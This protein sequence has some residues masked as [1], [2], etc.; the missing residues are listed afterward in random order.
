MS[1]DLAR[2]EAKESITLILFTIIHYR[3][4]HSFYTYKSSILPCDIPKLRW[5][6][7]RH[8][9]YYKF[10]IVKTF[11]LLPFFLTLTLQEK[12]KKNLVTSIIIKPLTHLSK[13]KEDKHEK[14]MVRTILGAFSFFIETP[15]SIPPVP[16]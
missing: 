8:L 15:K 10:F 16:R 4:L 11:P 9:S 6:R 1:H 2:T 3:N 13:K 12:Q 7:H 14:G 5:N